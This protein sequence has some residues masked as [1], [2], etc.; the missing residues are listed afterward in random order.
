[1]LFA[2]IYLSDYLLSVSDYK[3][4]CTL[5]KRGRITRVDDEA[6]RVLCDHDTT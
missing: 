5:Q 2:T 4:T 6:H 1:M 3:R